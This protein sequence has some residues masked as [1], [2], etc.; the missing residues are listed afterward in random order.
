MQCRQLR[1]ERVL[2]AQQWR[3]REEW[4][5]CCWGW[6]EP[7]PAE[8]LHPQGYFLPEFAALVGIGK[9]VEE[10]KNSRQV[11]QKAGRWVLMADLISQL[12][13]NP[14]TSPVVQHAPC[15]QQSLQES[16]GPRHP[17]AR[18]GTCPSPRRQMSTCT[19]RAAIFKAGGL[20][21]K[22]FTLV[23]TLPK[24]ACFQLNCSKTLGS[25]RETFQTSAV[26]F[27]QPSCFFCTSQRCL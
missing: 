7:H 5:S 20:K 23:E 9:D 26:L 15:L 11:T 4:G 21:I 1:Q 16:L 25:K 24:S 18:H 12:T 8:V 2:S 13:Q 10:G 3:H 6:G 17:T 14:Q 22:G 19:P 27:L